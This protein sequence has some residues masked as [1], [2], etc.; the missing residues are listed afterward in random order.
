MQ[1]EVEECHEQEV[2]KPVTNLVCNTVMKKV[3][4]TSKVC[5]VKKI[6]VFPVLSRDITNQTHPGR[7]ILDYSRPGRVW[8]VTSHLGAGKTITFF[9]SVYKCIKTVSIYIL[10][11]FVQY[12][13]MGG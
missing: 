1:E 9:Y 11:F 10:P 13:E 5:T 7:E 6:I 8:S 12:R 3:I 2:C 4:F